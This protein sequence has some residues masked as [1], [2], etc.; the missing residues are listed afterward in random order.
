MLLCCAVLDVV[1]WQLQGSFLAHHA[2]PFDGCHS[3]LRSRL[4]IVKQPSCVVD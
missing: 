4:A 1:G 3:I 2:Q